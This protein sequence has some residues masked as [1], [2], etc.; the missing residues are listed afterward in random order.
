MERKLRVLITGGSGQLGSE[1]K[2]ITAGS[3]I[4]EYLF[5]TREDL[6]LSDLAAIAP[7]LQR[8]RPDVIVHA[9]AYT[10]VDRAEE[11]PML[12]DRLNHLA[13]KEIAQ[14]CGSE[15]V[16]LLFVSTDYVYP[17]D[18]NAPLKE[19]DSTGP[20]N[21]YGKTKLLGEV[22]AIRFNPQTL[23]I[24]TSWVYSPYG[25]NF[26]KTMLRLMQEKSQLRVVD[27]QF[28]SPTC[29]GD[30]ARAI[31][32]IVEAGP[33]KPG[34][35][36]YCNAGRCSWF[37][38]AIAISELAGLNCEVLPVPSELYPTVAKRPR[39]TVLDTSKIKKEFDLIIPSW[40]DSLEAMLQALTQSRFDDKLNTV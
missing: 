24:R 27:D 25:H 9:A 39:F 8:L 29:A 11:E 23:V 18:K 1:L 40:K 19:Q 32:R 10:A 37:E 13:T 3:G 6:D 21:I 17:G 14:Y 34:T 28:G 7:T 12:A 36:H 20:L 26:V 16:K 38:F 30:L 33:W 4:A 31:Q 15:H 5:P 22:A 2:A 35:Y